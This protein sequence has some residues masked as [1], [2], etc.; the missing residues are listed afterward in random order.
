M[1]NDPWNGMGMDVRPI[2]SSDLFG[3]NCN[4]PF[5]ESGS[6]AL[7]NCGMGAPKD[8]DGDY[9]VRS[10]AALGGEALLRLGRGPE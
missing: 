2:T 9:C 4:F 8:E 7:F 5:L 6:H 3:P 10:E 1:W